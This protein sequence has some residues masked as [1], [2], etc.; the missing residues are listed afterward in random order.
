MDQDLTKRLTAP[1]S[2]E[3]SKY[4]VMNVTKAGDKASVAFYIDARDVM[5]RLDE[6][7][8]HDGWFDQYQIL[9]HERDRWVI[10]C[11]LTVNGVPKVDVGEGDAPKDAY[12]DAL[13]RAAVKHGIGRYLYD[14]DNGGYYAIDSYKKFTPEAVRA[15]DNLL[16]K[17][18]S[19]IGVKLP[20]PPPS[21]AS[22]E[23]DASSDPLVEF[24]GQE[25]GAEVK[26]PVKQAP[27]PPQAAS[28][29]VTPDVA[30]SWRNPLDAQAWARKELG[31]TSKDA[32]EHWTQAV[33]KCN[34]YSNANKEEVFAAYAA[35][36]RQPA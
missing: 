28:K 20:P 8:G 33:Q 13:K 36:F 3:Q 9:V 15:I 32:A 10:E 24:A 23:P 34:G 19:K 6:V 7:V 31:L 29:L 4:R 30:A 1:F 17:N 27:P 16:R 26:R 21:P 35:L 5:D 18:L 2:F 11:T 14:M 22:G 12:S 25:L